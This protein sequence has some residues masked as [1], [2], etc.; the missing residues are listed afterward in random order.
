MSLINSRLEVFYNDQIAIICGSSNRDLANRICQ[1]LQNCVNKTHQH[2][3]QK[4][5]DKN[6][7]LNGEG[8]QIVHFLENTVGG[9]YT[10][11]PPHITVIHETLGSFSNG[12]TRVQLSSNIRRKDVYIVQSTDL[13]LDKKP[14]DNLMELLC[15][16]RACRDSSARTIVP[17]IPCLGYQ[18][19]DKKDESRT[20]TGAKLVADLIETASRGASM[21]VILSALHAGQ[22][23]SFFNNPADHLYL[24]DYLIK[25]FLEYYKKEGHTLDNL[26]VISP[27]AGAAKISEKIAKQMNVPFAILSKQRAQAG[28][29]DHMTLNVPLEKIKGKYLVLFD[30][31][32]DTG[33][34]ACKAA[35]TLISPEFGALGVYFCAVHGILSGPAFERLANSKFS[36]IFLTN[37]LENRIPEDH[38]LNDK[39]IW[40][41]VSGHFGEAIFRNSI[42]KSLGEIYEKRMTFHL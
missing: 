15:I 29:V 19:Q 10:P 18:R 35:D 23:Q 36:K 9:I 13:S 12:E 30:D 1:Y 42:G 39:I 24:S 40:V 5:L 38:P 16:I 37:T 27:D 28:V 7:E 33:G 2:D 3:H 20:P 11:E 21:K 32:I 4:M 26:M 8:Q 14:N 25:G 6:T 34:T 22:I 41:D 17:V 31:M